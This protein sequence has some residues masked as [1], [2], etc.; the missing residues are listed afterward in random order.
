[1]LFSVNMMLDYF[2]VRP[3]ESSPLTGED[4]EPVLSLSKDEEEIPQGAV[5]DGAHVALRPLST[6]EGRVPL[7]NT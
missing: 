5:P 2:T 1:M 6:A 3:E 7:C 4:S